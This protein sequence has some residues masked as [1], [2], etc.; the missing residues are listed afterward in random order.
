[1]TSGSSTSSKQKSPGRRKYKY[2]VANPEDDEGVPPDYQ[3]VP[4]PL[5]SVSPYS[6]HLAASSKYVLTPPILSP[7]K[8]LSDFHLSNISSTTP[9]SPPRASSRMGDDSTWKRPPITVHPPNASAYSSSSSSHKHGSSSS[10]RKHHFQATQPLTPHVLPL[11]PPPPPPMLPNSR[12]SD[13]RFSPSELPS[14]SCDITS[15]SMTR[16][17]STQ[18]AL[19]RP[20]IDDVVQNLCTYFPNR[21]LDQP[22]N[23]GTIAFNQSH[24]RVYRSLLLR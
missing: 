12:I 17:L 14:S 13:A 4:S 8:N 11:P 20:N 24:G 7:P 10:I 16:E 2:H 18:S 3:F 6:A 21:D 15:P 9:T 1:M 23:R 19:G 5:P 22:I